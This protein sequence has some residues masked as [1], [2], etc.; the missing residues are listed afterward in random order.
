MTE[1][2][3]DREFA[4]ECAHHYIENE[5]LSLSVDGPRHLWSLCEDAW[6]RYKD[7]DASVSESF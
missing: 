6:R 4:R 2:N 1:M 5:I 3:V 7:A